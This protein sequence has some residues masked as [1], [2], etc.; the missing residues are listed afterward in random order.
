M[1]IAEDLSIQ[2][3][4]LRDFGNLESQLAA[5]ARIGF[6]RV[7]LIGSHLEQPKETRARLDVHGLSAP[8]AHVSMDA[9]RDNLDRVAEQASIIGVKELYMPALPAA[10][11]NA[12]ADGWRRAGAELGW[13]AQRM[14]AHGVG[15]G[16]HNHDWELRTFEDGRTALDHFFS[17]ADG[18]P[19]TFEAD[20]AWLVRGGA[21]PVDWMRSLRNRLTAVHVKDLAAEGANPEEEGWS[22]VGAGTLDWPALWREATALGAKYMILEHDK[23]K[24]PI[25]FA[26]ASR[27]YLLRQLA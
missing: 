16:Y 2:L 9:L 17:G 25:E 10:E 1:N 6:K 19:L 14:K 4:S 15:L 27:A 23:P 8:T 24:D 26:E 7:E 13:F 21:D 18:S 5:L 22:N 11:R 20:L 3:Y 12:N